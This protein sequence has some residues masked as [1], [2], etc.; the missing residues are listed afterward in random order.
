MGFFGPISSPL[1]DESST[2]FVRRA[3]HRARV[4]GSFA[5]VQGVVQMVGFFSGILLVRALSSTEYAYFTIANTMQ[6]TINLLADIGISVGLISI[7]GRVWH[8]RNR[9]GQLINTA[10]AVRRK[11]GALAIVVITP[12][13]YFMLVRNGAS[14]G[15]T[16]ILI[17]VIL[18]GLIVQLSLGVLSVVPRLRS[19]LGRI[20]SIDLTGAFTRLLLIGGLLYLFMNAGVAA[21]IGT[22]VLFLQ[23]LM[24]RHYVAG[25]VDLTAPENSDDRREIMRLTKHLAANAVFYCVQGQI[26]IFLIGFFARRVSSIAE[27]GALGR[28]GMIFI[29]VSNLLTNVFVPAFARCDSRR[30]LRWLFFAIVGAVSAFSAVIMAAAA[31]FPNQFLFILGNRYAHLHHELLLMVGAA[32]LNAIAGTLWALNASKAWVAGSWL[33]IPL[34]LATQAALIPFTDFSSVAGVLTFNLL[35]LIPSLLLNI[36]LSVRGFRYFQSVTT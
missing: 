3:L 29:V 26:T 10:L 1:L 17:V 16:A 28:L 36:F 24:F 14:P 35:S 8:D 4:V 5:V 34:T 20:Q 21:L 32:V 33:Y 22:G 11:L 13:M 27:V 23:Y 15:Y 12:I 9:F 7:G 6:G 2:P 19:D 31:W 30:R 18:L 25:A